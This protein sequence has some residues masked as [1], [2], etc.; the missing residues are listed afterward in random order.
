MAY[1]SREN[2]FLLFAG[3]FAGTLSAV[4]AIAPVLIERGGGLPLLSL[5]IL[6]LVVGVSGLMASVAA[7][8]TALRSPLLP[9]LRSE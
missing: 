1:Y 2:A 8:I 9:A 3:V 5:A 7:T 4:V 6:L